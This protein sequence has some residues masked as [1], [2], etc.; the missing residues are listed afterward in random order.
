MASCISDLR[1][2]IAAHAAAASAA[3]SAGHQAQAVLVLHGISGSGKS[4]LMGCAA[5]AAARANPQ[6]MVLL[7]FLGTTP[8]SSSVRH[9]LTS[10]CEQIARVAGSDKKIPKDYQELVI[11]F[12]SFLALA[13]AEKP[14]VLF[15]DS[16][17]QLSDAGEAQSLWS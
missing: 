16:L 9:V 14:I 13:T 6:A 7:R 1:E 2:A 15:F 5:L 11:E 17:D 12:P 10:I 8:A 4:A 3:T